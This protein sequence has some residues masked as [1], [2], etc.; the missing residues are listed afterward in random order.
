MQQTWMNDATDA[1]V[2]LFDKLLIAAYEAEK[3]ARSKMI[4][5]KLT[6][7]TNMSNID[8]TNCM[9]TSWDV[10]NEFVQRRRS[11]LGRR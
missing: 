1:E 2:V 10:A 9:A 7:S 8:T 3:T 11:M 6:F 4:E 5:P